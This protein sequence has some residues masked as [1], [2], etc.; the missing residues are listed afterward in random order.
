MAFIPTTDKRYPL[1]TDGEEDDDPIAKNRKWLEE[2]PYLVPDSVLGKEKWPDITTDEGFAELVRPSS[3]MSSFLGGPTGAAAG[4]ADVRAGATAENRDPEAWE[5]GLGALGAIPAV[6]AIRKIPDDIWK[7]PFSLANIKGMDK[8]DE[9]TIKHF[10]DLGVEGKFVSGKRPPTNL[11]ADPYGPLIRKYAEAT[12]MGEDLAGVHAPNLA[13]AIRG[14]ADSSMAGAKLLH[15]MPL[16]EIANYK[17][18]TGSLLKFLGLDPIPVTRTVRQGHP[19]RGV[20]Y[21]TSKTSVA[22]NANN[23]FIQLNIPAMEVLA[24]HLTQPQLEALTTAYSTEREVIRLPRQV[25][26][27]L[28][29]DVPGKLGEHFQ[30]KRPSDWTSNIKP[31]VSKVA[32]LAP[33]SADISSD[34]SKYLAGMGNV[35][36]FKPQYAVDELTTATNYLANEISSN[37]VNSGEQVYNYMMHRKIL[38]PQYSPYNDKVL[39]SFLN[40]HTPESAMILDKWNNIAADYW[41]T[42]QKQLPKGLQGGIEKG[43]LPK[44]GGGGGASFQELKKLIAEGTVSEKSKVSW[45]NWDPAPPGE[46]PTS[47]PTTT[48]GTKDYLNKLPDTIKDSLSAVEMNSIEGIEWG[49]KHKILGDKYDPEY[50]ELLEKEISIVAK[51]DFNYGGWASRQEQM[52]DYFLTRLMLNSNYSLKGDP[53]ILAQPNKAQFPHEMILEYNR[54]AKVHKAL[55]G[56]GY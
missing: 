15:D 4:L 30:F 49:Y 18:I 52:F 29:E 20:S 17:Q 44:L 41:S 25:L 6:G 27:L 12:E 26:Q 38:N 14:Y 22:G 36:Q 37:G 1:L 32:E 2:N 9:P 42:I 35:F 16:Q 11:S 33:V 39:S 34:G 31:V 45:D 28:H 10:A 21:S 47:Y 23:P 3:F 53:N 54:A 19:K 50:A 56:V 48:S 43:N 40:E 55:F 24:S 13:N 51:N 46:L 8:F 5:W 7:L